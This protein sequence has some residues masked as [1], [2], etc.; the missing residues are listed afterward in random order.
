MSAPKLP[1]DY[2]SREVDKLYEKNF[3]EKDLVS[4][5]E[6]CAFIATFINAC[7]WTEDEFHN[8]KYEVDQRYL[9]PKLN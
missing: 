7:G 9:N 3:D 4:I 1:Y 8:F 5:D 6:H 2:V